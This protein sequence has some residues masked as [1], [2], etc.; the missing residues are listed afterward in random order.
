MLAAAA[1]AAVAASFVLSTSMC[2]DVERSTHAHSS[3]LHF[4][5]Q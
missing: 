2:R 1:A 5:T 4:Y 3:K